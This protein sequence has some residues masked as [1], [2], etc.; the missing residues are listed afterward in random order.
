MSAQNIESVGVGRRLNSWKEIGAYFGKDERTVKRWEAQRRLPIHRLPGRSGTTVFAFTGELDEWLRNGRQDRSSVEP[1]STLLAPDPAPAPASIPSSRSRRQLRAVMALASLVVIV[2]AGGGLLVARHGVVQPSPTAAVP[3]VPSAA[4][5][6]AADL[7]LRGAYYWNTRT[8]ENLGRAR[9]L[10][11]A[12]IA[13]D[14]AYA[15]AYVGLANTY[16]L[17]AQYTDM[18]AASA[19]PLA[20]DAAEHAIRLNPDLAPAYAALAFNAFYWS[21]DIGK[22]RDLFRRSLSLDPNSSQT[23]HWYALVMMHTGD[24]AEPLR[25]IT[26]A[27]EL[28][29]QSRS[30]LANKG[31]ITFY[32][33]RIDEAERLLEDL[34]ATAPEFLPPHYYLATIHLARG[35]YPAYLRETL[36]AASL[37]NNAEM[38]ATYS[39]ARDALASGG[40]PAMF[41]VIL[42]HQTRAYADGRE[43]AFN[44]A[45]TAA[46]LGDRPTAI[47]YLQRSK[48]AGEPDFNAVRID[49]A[50]ATLRDDAEYQKLAATVF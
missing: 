13:R 43:A 14:P 33:G 3:A 10:F 1:A 41:Q 22:A 5:T 35:D 17:L 47:Q 49:P 25:A 45:R 19:Y 24:L 7:Y 30:I 36:A 48:A 8:P 40:P 12:A 46:L 6:E 32:A 39:E 23:L 4:R 9:D 18:P 42:D 34:S 29:P 15:D 44:V 11:N 21:H 31:L 37:E 16:N 28:E 26:R 20:R 38:T 2:V 27:Q 50:L